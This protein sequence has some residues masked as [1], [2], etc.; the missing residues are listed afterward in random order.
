[1]KNGCNMGKS[2]AV[3]SGFLLFVVDN[4][5]EAAKP[6]YHTERRRNFE[7]SWDDE[8]VDELKH[9][10]E[11]CRVFLFYPIYWVAFSQMLN[12]FISQGR[13]PLKSVSEAN[14]RVDVE[15]SWYHATPRHPQRYHAE[16]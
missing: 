2:N 4:V 10:L 14:D 7:M 1:M 6:S 15:T 3:T 13:Y 16:Y 5:A 12:N 9:G 8:Y 11:A